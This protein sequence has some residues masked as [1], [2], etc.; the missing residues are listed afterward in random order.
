M[1]TKLLLTF[2]LII[3]PF[4]SI[5]KGQV[6]QEWV[7]RYNGPG[8]NLDAPTAM[9]I[10][11]AENVYVTGYSVGAGTNY[12]YVTIKY[13]SS[14]VQQWV[15]RYNGPANGYDRA[16]S[17]FVDASGYVYVTG[18]SAGSGTGLDIATIKYASDGT[19]QWIQRYNGTGN[20]DDIGIGI[21]ATTNGDVYVVGNSQGAGTNIDIVTIKYNE[22]GI[23]Q[24][25]AR[26]NDPQNGNDIAS[27]VILDPTNGVYITGTTWNGSNYDVITIKYAISGSNWVRTFNGVGNGNDGGNAIAVD[28]YGEVYVTGY[29]EGLG[30]NLDYLTLQYDVTGVLNWQARQNGLGNGNDIAKSIALDNN[31][32]V[33]VTGTMFGNGTGYDIGTYK[34]NISGGLIWS[35]K[36]NLNTTTNDNG[37]SI[38]VTS[39]GNV[40]V[41]GTTFLNGP[42]YVTLKYNS[43]GVQQWVA[44]Y[45][46]PGSGTD[47]AF[48]VKA[49]PSGNV[50][51]TGTSFNFGT[52][53]DIATVKYSQPTSIKNIN[54][55]VPDKFVLYQNYP[56]PFN[57]STK[58]K[59]D[60]P[61]SKNKINQ[62]VKLILYDVLG[63]E[64]G[65][66]LNNVLIPGSYEI[67]LNSENPSNLLHSRGV[68]FYKL[69]AGD[70]IDTKKMILIK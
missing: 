68:Y 54:S 25:V 51:A 5:L 59:F 70:L 27:A 10:D 28:N 33:Y 45:N 65:T 66:I 64:L 55:L 12:D 14:G 30:T 21:V 6:T 53:Y 52:Y 47:S 31:G 49:A 35:E 22:Q 32:F 56:N 18:A 50:Y 23:Q 29:S 62:T 69:S 46:G 48:V 3:L 2:V 42:D 41:S 44:I 11:A 37:N 13:N 20:A 15:Q 36:Y 67:E 26:Y 34:Y 7:Q 57:P 60:I 24:W 8:N 19:V 38:S 17:I 9:V 58:I 16:Y 40:Y 39:N 61:D 63:R 43:T 4:N 1:K